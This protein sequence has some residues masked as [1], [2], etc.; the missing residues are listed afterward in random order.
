[1][2]V[3]AAITPHPP[4]SI[5][6]IGTPE[7][8]EAVEKTLQSFDVLR[9]ELERTDPDTLIIISPHGQLEPYSFV[10]NSSSVLKGSFDK[11]GLDDVFEYQNDI[12]FA[13][14][15]AFAGSMN[16]IPTHLHESFLDHGALIPLYHLLKNIHPKVIHLSF[17][18]MNY[19][20][21]YRY[22]EIIRCL[23]D[24]K[25]GN[26]IAVVASADLS[27]KLT[28]LSPAGY[29]PSAQIFDCNILHYLG[30]NDEASIMKL[31]SEDTAEAAECGIRSI[32]ML[33]GI[34]HGQKYE[35]NLL[36]YEFPFGIGYMTA[37]L[38]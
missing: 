2:L 19:E 29:S 38:L 27:H 14:K 32:V 4:E 24:K 9:Q 30:A 15:L 3:F 23:I 12:E 20:Q 34:L 5:P 28:P 33:L 22:G 6:G 16:E 31:H 7:D 17:S 36:S 21:H 10:I 35:F 37:R 13:D 25:V 26:R 8:I 11:F 18:L 1:M